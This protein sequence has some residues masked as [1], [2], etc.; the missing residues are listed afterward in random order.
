MA[1]SDHA[2]REPVADVKNPNAEQRRPPEREADDDGEQHVDVHHRVMIIS[3]PIDG[4]GT[5]LSNTGLILG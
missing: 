1:E 4:P 3:E 2:S 5:T